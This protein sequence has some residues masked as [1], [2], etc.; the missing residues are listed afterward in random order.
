MEMQKLFSKAFTYNAYQQYSQERFAQG[1][2]TGEAEKV[3]TEFYLH[4]TKMN[5]SR[6]KRVER[7]GTL[8]AGL[9][10]T[11]D[12][13]KTPQ[14]WLVVAESWCGDVPHNLPILQKMTEYQPLIQL[15]L[16]LRDENLEVMDQYLTN[17]GRSIPKL[18][19]FDENF[20]KELFTWG[21]R[22]TSLQTYINEQKA[23]EVPME[24]VIENTQKWYNKNKAEALQQEFIQLLT[25][26]DSYLI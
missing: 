18:I 7:S 9:Q 17:G 25:A 1:K 24:T 22:P 3:N 15:R 20:T 10:S 16:I 6:T 2:T 13:I 8:S 11:L 23:K 14:N 21:P 12:T 4:Y 5:L 19:A 26:I